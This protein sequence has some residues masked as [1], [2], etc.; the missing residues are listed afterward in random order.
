MGFSNPIVN[1]NFKNIRKENINRFFCVVKQ[2]G[3]M[4]NNFYLLSLLMLSLLSICLSGCMVAAG[5][6]AHEMIET[7]KKR[8]KFMYEYQV[9]NIERTQQGLLPLDLCTE[10]YKFDKNWAKQDRSCEEIVKTLEPESEVSKFSSRDA[11][12][13]HNMGMK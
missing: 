4:N 13:L 10:K 7:N 5:L 1:M 8:D 11:E 3:Q 6:A 12:Q 9:T 2:L